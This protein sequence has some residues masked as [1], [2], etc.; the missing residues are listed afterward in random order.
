MKKLS[1]IA[2]CLLLILCGFGA[3][4][5][6]QKMEIVPAE[7]LTE[8]QQECWGP[9]SAACPSP[10]NKE[11]RGEYR[12]CMR[13]ALKFCGLTEKPREK[14]GGGAGGKA[15]SATLN[16]KILNHA[17]KE[18]FEKFKKKMSPKTQEFMK[19]KLP[20]DLAPADAANAGTWVEP[21]EPKPEPQKIPEH[22][23]KIFNKKS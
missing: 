3:N 15:R 21:P 14:H 2:H 22:I 17:S 19:D 11:R 20:A 13:E 18:D 5:A 6:A 8:A 23:K 10:D 7:Q 12:Q 4:A 9:A 16:E 1:L